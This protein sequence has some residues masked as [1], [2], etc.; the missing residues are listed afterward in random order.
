MTTKM[1][2]SSPW[3]PPPFSVEKLLKDTRLVVR[4]LRS[5]T[6]EYGHYPILTHWLNLF[7]EEFEH[8]IRRAELLKEDGVKIAFVAPKGVGKSSILNGILSAW[9][10]NTNQSF[11]EMSRAEIL[12]TSAVL[13][14]GSGHTTPFETTFEFDESWSVTVERQADEWVLPRIEAVVGSIFRTHI[15]NSD[16]ISQRR[17]EHAGSD[18]RAHFSLRSKEI[19]ALPVVEIDVMRC[20]IGICGGR[21]FVRTTA[22]DCFCSANGPESLRDALI[23]RANYANRERLELEPDAGPPLEWLKNTLRSLTLGRLHRQPFPRSVTVRG[24]FV[25]RPADREYRLCLIDTLGLASVDVVSDSP[26]ESRLDLEG[27]MKAPWTLTVFVSGYTNP[28]EPVQQ[29]L[30]SVL[31][32]LP[33][34]LLP[35]KILVPILYRSESILINADSDESSIAQRESDAML[36]QVQTAE[37][38]NQML[39]ETGRN[40]DWETSHSPVVDLFGTLG[41]QNTIDRLA[42]ELNARVT[43]MQQGWADETMEFLAVARSFVDALADNSQ[44]ID[45][46]FDG[47]SSVALSGFLP[48]VFTAFQEYVPPRMA[49]PNSKDGHPDSP[50]T[51]QNL[52]WLIEAIARLQLNGEVGEIK[53]EP[54][55]KV[56][57]GWGVFRMT[58]SVRPL[59]ILIPSRVRFPG[60]TAEVQVGPHFG[61]FKMRNLDW[62]IAHVSSEE[63]L[64][65]SLS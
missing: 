3:Q 26:L 65:R 15:N 13:P 11:E 37:I 1:R 8:R 22:E 58:G 30:R 39:S 24:P 62:L 33:D 45:R 64:I 59:Q 49:R 56:W 42:C 25:P 53:I 28:P 14:L 23:D 48:Q 5:T 29:A 57:R 43:C 32:T 17:S 16:L 4:K 35:Q 2:K 19:L 47:D 60:V 44:I 40:R 41:P 52:R 9:V 34:Q 46:F 10:D 31:R 36:K 7:R 54:P 61:S 21:D 27:L 12:A 20:L 55:H 63:E 6:P 51:L 38:M 50:I 18:R